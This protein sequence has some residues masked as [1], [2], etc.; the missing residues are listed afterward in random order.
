MIVLRMMSKANFK[1][2]QSSDSNRFFNKHKFQ[3]YEI[4][5]IKLIKCLKLTQFFVQTLLA[6]P[7]F[8]LQNNLNYRNF[9]STYVPICLKKEF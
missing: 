5:R 6:L 4:M 1:S 9:N 7:L 8:N 2:K 3:V